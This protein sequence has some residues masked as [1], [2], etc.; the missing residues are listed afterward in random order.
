M[1]KTFL[2]LIAM[3]P[4]LAYAQ[5]SATT[6]EADF[7]GEVPVVYSV[8]RLPQRLDET[9]GAVTVL[10]RRTIRMSG[11]R[12]VVDLLRLVPGMRTSNSF[13]LGPTGASY[14]G[15]GPDDAFNRIQVFVD[16]RSVY[17]HYLL[18]NVGVGLGAVALEDIERI[19]VM[20]GTNSAAYG[21][22]AFLGAINIVTRD[23]TETQGV[24][25]SAAGGDNGIRDVMARWGGGA[26]EGKF[27]LSADRR[28]D[29]GLSGTA[30]GPA[31][32]RAN[33]R[34]DL[35]PYAADRVELRAGGV[36]A[37][38]GV[39]LAGFAGNAPR[40]RATEEQYL[41]LDWRRSVDADHD[42]AVQL[43]HA[44][45]R[46]TDAFDYVPLPGL[47][48]DYSGRYSASSLSA[49]T[50]SRL[51]DTLRWVWGAE[52][53]REDMSSRP[54]FDTDKTFVTDFSRLF[55]NIEWR[56]RPNWLLNAGAMLED[57]SISG[58][59]LAPRAALNWHVQ[60]GHTVRV[61]ISQGHRT[62]SIYEKYGN[63]RYYL[64]GTLLNSTVVARGGIEPE[65][66]YAREI[67]YLF[68]KPGVSLDLRVFEE[69]IR[70]GSM[71]QPYPLANGV[72]G[73]GLATD[74]VNGEDQDMR[75]AEYQ[76]KW[77]PWR[78]GQIILNQSYVDGGR[79][80]NSTAVPP[81]RTWGLMFMQTLPNGID[82]S[83][84]YYEMGEHYF[85]LE[86]G[87]SPDW[88]SP[89]MSRTDVRVAMPVH[90][91]RRKGELAFVVQ[92]LGPAYQESAM[93]FFFRRQAYVKLTVE[94]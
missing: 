68:D 28:A 86:L 94:N 76:L 13:E 37:T 89:A 66:V 1:R 7:F 56:V 81:F 11:A 78:N 25:A 77:Q 45:G 30:G 53:R 87:L 57:S 17:S 8:S 91:G 38:S 60:P 29:D 69:R 23:T 49:Q 79:T 46:F 4:A 63:I 54:V 12:D 64:N 33:F 39:G 73:N 75:G 62:P 36:R 82:M 5:P 84:M 65:R 58:H 9:P 32:E 50:T 16:G 85:P 41:Q 52:L 19:E 24:Y 26:D 83:L 6:S 31:L 43:S 34:A 48:V 44:M 55:G 35:R 15:T 67:G 80:V 92:N 71:Q 72:L 90:L 59:Q 42:W 74:Y 27:R 51:N 14:H 18:G 93:E 20:R 70:G 10:D 2:F 40:T 21:A 88:R 3:V 61:G 22:R 47:V